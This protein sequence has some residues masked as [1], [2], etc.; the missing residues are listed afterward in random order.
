MCLKPEGHAGAGGACS[1]M[2]SYYVAKSIALKKCFSD[3]PNLF[4]TDCLNFE[5]R[6]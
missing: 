4:I 6:K 2:W 5:V 1:I 3:F